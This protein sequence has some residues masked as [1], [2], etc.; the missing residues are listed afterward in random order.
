MEAE[1][2]QSVLNQF[3][4]KGA[5]KQMTAS[6]QVGAGTKI[7]QSVSSSTGP[8]GSLNGPPKKKQDNHLQGLFHV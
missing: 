4:N 1:T 3:V 6:K 8:G 2:F 7:G 5:L